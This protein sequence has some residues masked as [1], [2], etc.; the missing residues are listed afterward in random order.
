M[1]PVRAAAVSTIEI[2]GFGEGE[3]EEEAEEG[4]G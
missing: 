2:C 1:V 3:S 4:E